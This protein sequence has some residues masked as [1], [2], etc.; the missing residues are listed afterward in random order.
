MGCVGRVPRLS[1]VCRLRVDLRFDFD[2]LRPRMRSLLPFVRSLGSRDALGGDITPLLFRPSGRRLGK[3]SL[4]VARAIDEADD[5][6]RA[7]G[8]QPRFVRGEDGRSMTLSPWLA[9][10]DTITRTREFA[11]LIETWRQADTFAIPPTS[12]IQH[13]YQPDDDEGSAICFDIE[14]TATRL[15]GFPAIAVSVHGALDD[16]STWLSAQDS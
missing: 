12:E 16:S 1:C 9:S 15:F 2:C 4:E 6:R 13:V 10:S 11:S 14:R 8:L 7:V 5:A 3:L